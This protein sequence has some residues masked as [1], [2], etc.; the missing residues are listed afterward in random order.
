MLAAVRCFVNAAMC[1][2]RCQ[3]VTHTRANLN[4]KLGGLV[5]ELEK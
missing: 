3:E 4:E 2:L 1:R 5:G